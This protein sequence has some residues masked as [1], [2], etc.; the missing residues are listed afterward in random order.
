MTLWWHLLVLSSMLLRFF[1]DFFFPIHLFSGF[2]IYSSLSWKLSCLSQGI[3]L[4]TYNPSPPTQEDCYKLEGYLDYTVILRPAW[5]TEQDSVLR[6]PKKERKFSC[7]LSIPGLFGFFWNL[8]SNALPRSCQ[9][10]AV[11][12]S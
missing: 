10:S 2:F 1:W 5:T 3:V 12:L 7:P 8:E 4:H 9:A 11:P 6:K